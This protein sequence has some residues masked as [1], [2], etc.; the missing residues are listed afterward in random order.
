VLSQVLNYPIGIEGASGERG[1]DDLATGLVYERWDEGDG[2]S[3]GFRLRPGR[4]YP[5]SPC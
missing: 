2:D 1:G 3:L 5:S 4:L